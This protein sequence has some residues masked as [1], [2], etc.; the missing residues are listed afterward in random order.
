MA[1]TSLPVARLLQLRI[2]IAWQEAVAVAIAAEARSAAD[3]T[4]ITLEQCR[5]STEGRVL[6]DSGAVRSR[7]DEVSP[8]QL[9]RALIEGQ[10]A[11]E[12]LRAL[13]ATAEDALASFPSERE[14]EQPAHVDLRHFASP[15]PEL[16]IA[17]LA[18][19]GLAAGHG[20]AVV[21]TRVIFSDSGVAPLVRRR[22][23]VPVQPVRTRRRP[24]V[25]VRVQ[26]PS[27]RVA[28]G[29]AVLFLALAS[30]AAAMG[31][32]VSGVGWPFAG[33]S[34][35]ELTAPAQGAS[36]SRPNPETRARAPLV[37]DAA[38][39][40]VPLAGLA[41]TA[42]PAALAAAPEAATATFR[43]YS[44]ADGDVA[45]P[46]LLRPQMPSAP[47]SDGTREPS[48]LVELL[49]DEDG[50]VQRVRL[51][52][53]SPSV[54][55]HMILAAAK[56]WRFRPATRDGQPVPYMLRMPVTR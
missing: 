33:L 22:P 35:P 47:R 39:S 5:I 16:E 2:P 15:H 28:V 44:S 27:R 45:P 23:R 46:V 17:R 10:S 56:A 9:L 48:A 13:A 12:A 1:A 30:A 50:L 7:A 49:V 55:D 25:T 38:P 41:V 3:A 14:D 32:I 4:P 51:E 54:K 11:P 8:L 21:S 18:E 34:G 53:A 31:A 37:S 42:A 36:R 6:L 26:Q 24:G 43:A 20:A 29:F 52:S 19:R 40:L